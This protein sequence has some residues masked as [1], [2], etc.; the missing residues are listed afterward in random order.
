MNIV[1]GDIGNTVIKICIINEKSFKIKKEF[2][3]DSNKIY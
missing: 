3:F 2:R 1:I